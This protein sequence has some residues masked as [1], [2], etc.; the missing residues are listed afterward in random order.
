MKPNSNEPVNQSS[1]QSMH[2]RSRFLASACCLICVLQFGCATTPDSSTIPYSIPFSYKGLGVGPTP[3]AHEA[4]LQQGQELYAVKKAVVS[5]LQLRKAA[6]VQEAENSI[7][8]DGPV[9][10]SR[11]EVDQY[12]GA[13]A[14]QYLLKNDREYGIKYT[15]GFVL[16][17]PHIDLK[18]AA[19]LSERGRNN[20]WKAILAGR[21]YDSTYFTKRFATDIES[22]LV[23]ASKSEPKQP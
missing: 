6:P 1:E 15:I 5:A 18:I 4:M 19:L 21:E 17:P 23:E 13:S 3:N 11:E 2:D 8:S 14:P 16:H 20:P 12:N 7:V 22:A 9:Q 10:L